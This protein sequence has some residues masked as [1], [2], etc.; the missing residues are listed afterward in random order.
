[1]N[2]KDVLIIGGGVSG[3][4]AA[5]FLKDLAN[6]TLVES[7]ARLGGHANT[8]TH[9]EAGRQVAVDTGFMV[10]NRPNYP[11]LSKWFDDL[12]VKTYPTDMSFSV[13]MRPNGVEYNGSDLNGL[14]AQRLNLVSPRFHRM[15]R[16][17]LRFNKIATNDLRNDAISS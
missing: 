15:I 13:S 2:K 10:F 5:W 14:F 12:G 9:S 7:D 1:M 4:S 8:V 3:L 17:I 6:V 16:D 11:L